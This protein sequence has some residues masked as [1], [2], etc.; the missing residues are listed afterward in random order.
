MFPT[1]H[2]RTVLTLL[3]GALLAQGAAAD[4]KPQGMFVQ[5]GAGEQSARALSQPGN[6]VLAAQSLPQF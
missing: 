4:W 3:A 6:I 2:K 1:M 5:A